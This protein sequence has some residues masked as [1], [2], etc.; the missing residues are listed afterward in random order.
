MHG[1]ETDSDIDGRL[2]RPHNEWWHVRADGRADIFRVACGEMEVVRRLL[3]GTRHGRFR[4]QVGE[5]L[6]KEEYGNGSVFH[7]RHAACM[8]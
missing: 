4:C 2:C 6:P 7:I 5:R 1:D 8:P 3:D